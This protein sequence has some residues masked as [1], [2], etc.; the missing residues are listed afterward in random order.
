[1][2]NLSKVK[3]VYDLCKDKA[4][5]GHASVLRQIMEMMYLRMTTGISYAT[6]HYARM[7]RKDVSWEYKTGFMSQDFYKKEI[8]RLNDRKFHGVSQYKPLEKAYFS[9][10]GLQT[11]DYL[12]FFHEKNGKTPVGTSLCSQ[13]DLERLFSENPGKT[14]CFKKVEGHGGRGFMAFKITPSDNG[15]TLQKPGTETQSTTADLYYELV[16]E[17]DGWLIEDYLVQHP[18]LSRLNASSVN[19]LRMHVFQDEKGE[20]HILGTRLRVGAAG[21]LVDN[22]ELGGISCNVNIETGIVELAYHYS[23]IMNTLSHHPD[24]KEQVVGY[25]VPFWEEAK[26]LGANALSHMPKTRFLGLDI[27]ITE[28]G[29]VM[30]EMNIEPSMNGLSTAETPIRHIFKT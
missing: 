17:P 9:L 2:A 26:E 7:W 14:V 18:E 5:K 30:I 4:D 1:M 27:A 12:G 3:Y 8:L 20:I 22:N 13:E 21:S 25:K 19:T 16:K 11:P 24:S 28:E 10:F 29:P 15:T 6:Y 23:P